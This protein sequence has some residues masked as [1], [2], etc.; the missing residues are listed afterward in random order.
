MQDHQPTIFN[1]YLLIAA[2]W[3]GKWVIAAV[4]ALVVG[5]GAWWVTSQPERYLVT[6]PFNV[7][8]VPPWLCSDS[9]M[10]VGDKTNCK[11]LWLAN[12]LNE[13]VGFRFRLEKAFSEFHTAVG[14]RSLVPDLY[15]TA[16]QA[17]VDVTSEEL[18]AARAEEAIVR[19]VVSGRAG[20]DRGSPSD[21]LA[22]RLVDL[23]VFIDAIG[24]RQRQ[25]GVVQP[26]RVAAAHMR[27][28]SVLPGLLMLGLLLGAALALTPL[29]IRHIRD[30]IVRQQI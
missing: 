11:Q 18:A 6:I 12:R 7:D 5:L 17:A 20:D 21:A 16:Q 26:A 15:A 24:D 9:V 1:P 10:Q 19:T 25:V 29:V 3:R 14:D 30:G 4:T 13:K 22:E 28:R 2:L 27:L 23:R 8:T